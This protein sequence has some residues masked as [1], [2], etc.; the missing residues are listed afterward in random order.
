MS[1][2]TKRV[3]SQSKKG[4]VDSSEHISIHSTLHRPWST[5]GYAQV[6]EAILGKRYTL[7]I[8]LIGDA[9]ARSLNKTYRGKNGA[10]NVLSFPLTKCS[11]EIFINIAR[12][13]REASQYGLTPRQHAVFLLIHG[14]LH[15]KGYTHGSTME[16]AEQKYL[17]RFVLR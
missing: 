17:Q 8:V 5:T 3:A 11:G 10:S 7:S 14:C 13:K 15:L 1:S 4:D 9:R 16:R 6:A 2:S 12:V